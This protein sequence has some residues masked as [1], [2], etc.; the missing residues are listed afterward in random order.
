MD[1]GGRRRRCSFGKP[2]YLGIAGRS[3]FDRT[4]IGCGVWE[5]QDKAVDL[6]QGGGFRSVARASEATADRLDLPAPKQSKKTAASGW[7]QAATL[8]TSLE[9]GKDVCLDRQLPPTG[10]PL[11]KTGRHVSSVFP[12]RMP[13]DHVEKV[14]K[15]LL[16]SLT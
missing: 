9:S 2:H 7:P 11:G 15:Q 3:E 1:G 6:R 12:C 16:R 10:G 5:K 8:S 13:V 4:R 14:M